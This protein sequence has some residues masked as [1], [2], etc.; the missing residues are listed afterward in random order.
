MTLRIGVIADDLTGATDI[1]SFLVDSG[2]R[3]IQFNQSENVPKDTDAEAIVIGLKTRSIPAAEAVHQSVA[4][5]H[6]LQDA[7]AQQVIFKYCSTFDS[8]AQGNIGPVTDA[9]LD[10]LGEDFTVVVPALPV[11]GRTVYQGNLFVHGQPLHE[12]G[13][14]HHPV[15]PMRDANLLRLMEEQST[16]TAGLVPYETVEAGVDAVATHLSQLHQDNVRYAVI[17]TLNHQHLETIGAAISNVSL[18]T[19]GSGI[20]AGLGQALVSEYNDVGQNPAAS[21]HFTE[22]PAV[23]LSGSASDMTNAQVKR[24]CEFAPHHKIDIEALLQDSASYVTDVATWVLKN[25]GEYAPMVYATAPAADVAELQKQYGA[26]FL[27]AQIE[28][29]FGHLAYALREAGLTQFITAG[30]ETSGAATQA[31]GVDG[32]DVGPQ[33]AAGVPWVRSLDGQLDLA[34]KSGN[35]GDEDFFRTAQEMATASETDADGQ[36]AETPAETSAIHGPDAERRL[37]TSQGASSAPH[38]SSSAQER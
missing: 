18:V 28:T 37:G 31:L 12:S 13:M 36:E 17:D 30:G 3:T 7:G 14:R 15:T 8:T 27:S 35:F 10:A 6:R 19:G 26:E 38:P 32:F 34:L 21:W 16:G 4:A 20:A 2:L 1:A 23:V 29:F 9:L 5:L 24:Y 25:T 11:N 22:G 33:I